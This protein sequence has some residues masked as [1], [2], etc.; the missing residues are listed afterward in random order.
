MSRKAKGKK[1]CAGP[2]DCAGPVKRLWYK[3]N[4]ISAS[5]MGAEEEY[6]SSYSE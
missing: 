4:K 2:E 3:C 6:E 1:D 5:P